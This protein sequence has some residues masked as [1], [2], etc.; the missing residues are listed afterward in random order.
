MVA[1]IIFHVSSKYQ[2]DPRSYVS[3][4]ALQNFYDINLLG[5]DMKTNFEVKQIQ[6]G[7]T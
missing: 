5:E 7:K 2:I 4:V 1:N 6:F 3:G